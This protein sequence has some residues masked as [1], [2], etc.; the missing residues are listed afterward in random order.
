MHWRNRL[1]QI[2]KSIRDD[3]GKEQFELVVHWGEERDAHEARKPEAYRFNTVGEP[4]AFLF[5]L[6]E[7]GLSVSAG[8]NGFEIIAP[9]DHCRIC[10]ADRNGHTQRAGD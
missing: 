9:G 3:D 8:Y 6:S 1:L 7:Y 2:V 5:G 10:G 4:E